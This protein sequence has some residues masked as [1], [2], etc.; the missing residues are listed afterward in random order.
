ML[1]HNSVRSDVLVFGTMV[2]YIIYEETVIK[3]DINDIDNE[4]VIEINVFS[5]RIL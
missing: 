4:D 3:I 1:N 5:K 2:Q